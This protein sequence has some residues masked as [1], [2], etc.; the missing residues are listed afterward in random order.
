MKSGHCFTRLSILIAVCA[1]AAAPVAAQE[2]EDD[3]LMFEE[4]EEAARPFFTNEVELGGGHVSDDSFKFGEYTGL[5]DQGGF[6]IGNILLRHSGSYEDAHTEYWELIGRNLGLDSRYV[7]GEYGRQGLFGLYFEFDQI[8]HLVMDDGLTPFLGAGTTRQ[9]LPAGWVGAGATAGMTALVPSLRGVDIETERQRFG[10][11]IKWQVADRWQVRGNYRHEIKDGSDALGAI[12]ANTGGNPRGSVLAVPIDYKVDEFDVGV[13]YA[14]RTFQSSLSYSLS[15]FNNSDRALLFDNPFN[16]A[17]WSPGANFDD[18]AVGRMGLAPDNTA[19]NIAYAGGYNIGDRTRVTA[20]ISYGQMKQDDAFLPFS[21]VFAAAIPLPRPDLNGEIE[22][23]YVNVNFFTLLTNRIDLRAR[24]TYDDRNNQTPQDIYVV[25]PGD[26][27]VQQGLVSDRARVNRPYSMERHKF[28]VDTGYRFL[29]W[30]KLSAG[31]Q[32]EEKDRD[33]SEVRTTSEHTGSV[34]L[35]GNPFTHVDGWIRYS[36]SV[37]DGSTYVSNEPFLAGHNPAFVAAEAAIDPDLLFENDPL[38]RKYPFAD[39]DRTQLAGSMNVYP[40]ETVTFSIHGSY[41][42]DNYDRTQI[43]LREASNHSIGL[44]LSYNP[45]KD[46]LIYG[47]LSRENYY[48]RQLAFSRGGG[49]LAP[50]TDRIAVFGDRSWMVENR[51]RVNT[52]GAGFD[53]TVVEDKL[54]IKLDYSFSRSETEVKPASAAL[55]FLPLPDLESSVH[56]LN[57]LGQYRFTERWGMRVRY[58]YERFRTDDFA[59]DGVMPNTLAN[60]ILLGNSAPRYNEHLIGV[61]VF[62]EF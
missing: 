60:V 51:D 57:V 42:R 5:G 48:Y 9:T 8:P 19:W 58:L 16:N 39:R 35:S 44:D 3:E 4:A 31:Y 45:R 7:R 40:F 14:G 11:G 55:P 6:V 13:S 59:L 54:D 25:I 43:G 50:G 27:L 53:W 30:A 56:R 47:F 12:F 21:S 32:Y 26:S 46:F 41:N 15:L 23:V 49:I 22:T 10:G 38:L 37:R 17:A 52:G 34:K 36:Y 62:Y 61:S 29:D 33:F 1:F 28:E 24:Y 20:N 2:E 18:G